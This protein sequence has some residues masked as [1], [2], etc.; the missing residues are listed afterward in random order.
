MRFVFKLPQLVLRQAR[1]LRTVSM[2]RSAAR[3]PPGHAE[4][5]HMMQDQ[6]MT[7]LAGTA[8]PG[9]RPA[10]RRTRYWSGSRRQKGSPRP[11]DS[12]SRLSVGGR[13]APAQGNA[14]SDAIDP[15]RAAAALA[16]EAGQTRRMAIIASCAM[17]STDLS[18]RKQVADQVADA[19]QKLQQRALAA[20]LITSQRLPPP[21]DRPAFPTVAGADAGAPEAAALAR[22]G[23]ASWRHQGQGATLLFTALSHEGQGV[24]QVNRPR[25]FAP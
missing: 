24:N 14:R 13:A 25:R 22:A 20:A 15:G 21:A 7:P 23:V 5:D 19:G 11:T 3:R 16:A 17:S 2:G 8:D 6:G 9:A 4:S 1:R 18:P 12:R 10:C